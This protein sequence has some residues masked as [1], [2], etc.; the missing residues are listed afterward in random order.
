MSG[1][2][3]SIGENGGTT[4]EQLGLRSLTTA[5]PLSDLNYGQGVAENTGPDFTIH[6]KDGT[7]LAIDISSAATVGDVINLINNDPANLNPATRVVASLSP[8]GNGIQLFDGNIG[9]TD[10]LS[11]TQQ[12]GSDAAFDL[13]LIPR[14]STTATATTSAS[15]DTLTG[16]DPSPQEVAGL[17]NTL[18]RLH[19]ALTNFSH[20]KLARAVALLDD[21]YERV[22]FARS[23]LGARNQTIDTIKSQL[24][25]E[26]VQLKSNL[27]DVIDTNLP[28]T[29]AQLTA[30]QAALQASLQLTGIIFQTSLVDYI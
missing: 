24:D 1:A 17:F 2:D 28:E 13:G 4:A 12:F 3:F 30:R 9:G 20:E 26:T 7:D 19:D 21:D 14:G 16:A 25:D 22:N 29:I 15:G 10:T 11:V 5:T 8:F 18:Y 27:S 6:R 23:E